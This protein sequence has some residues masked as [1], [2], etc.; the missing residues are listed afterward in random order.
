MPAVDKRRAAVEEAAAGSTIPGVFH[1]ARNWLLPEPPPPV[2]EIHPPS[3]RTDYDTLTSE[4]V[5]QWLAPMDF[6][7]LRYL[8]PAALR[9]EHAHQQRADLITWL[10]RVLD[11]HPQW[12]R[13]L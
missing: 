1:P 10:E 4:Q 7:D 5:E 2:Q 13:H 8:I 9:Y 6:E 12:R 3:G 11:E